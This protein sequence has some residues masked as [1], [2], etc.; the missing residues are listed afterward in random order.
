MSVGPAGERSGGA[1]EVPY[2]A[3]RFEF[4]RAPALLALVSGFRL[5]RWFGSNRRTGTPERECANESLALT[6]STFTRCLSR[7]RS[8]RSMSRKSS[9]LSGGM[10]LNFSASAA[11]LRNVGTSSRVRERSSAPLAVN[12][13]IVSDI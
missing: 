10:H 3:A 8:A 1:Q 13:V 2:G 9:M 7:T 12:A 11:R 5:L 6:I 4:E